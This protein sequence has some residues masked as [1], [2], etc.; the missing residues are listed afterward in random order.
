M[1]DEKSEPSTNEAEKSSQRATSSAYGLAYAS[2]LPTL[3]K[4]AREHGYA[5]AVHGSMH[6]DL[7]L[8]A[9]PWTDDAT[10]AE[11]LIDS[12]RE[13]IDGFIT[14]HP[15]DGEKP[16]GRRAWS[17]VPSAWI[18]KHNGLKWQP[19]LDISVMPKQENTEKPNAN[20]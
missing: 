19:W 5:L 15:K 14:H 1:P 11:R 12:I 17:I 4:I 2:V 10:E 13:A 9:C 7:D 6:T 18:G 8:V 3:Q 20:Q 16:H